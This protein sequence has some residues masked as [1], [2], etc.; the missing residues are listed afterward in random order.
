MVSARF[1]NDYFFLVY[2]EKNYLYLSFKFK[3]SAVLYVFTD[4]ISILLNM[5]TII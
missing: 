4:T 3:T 5:L 1:L 2:L